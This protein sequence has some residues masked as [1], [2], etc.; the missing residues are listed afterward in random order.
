MYDIIASSFFQ[1]KTCRLPGIG[2]LSLINSS[3]ALDI[4]NGQIIAP[5][6]SI[7]FSPSIV[8]DGIFNEFSAISEVMLKRL[9]EV[10]SL[11][12]AGIGSF[13][14]NKEGIID[15]VAIKINPVFELPV[16]VESVIRQ[17][18]EHEILVGDK[19]TTNTV[20]SKMLHEQ[21]EVQ[22]AKKDFWWVWAILLGLIGIAMIAYYI[23]AFGIDNFGKV[24]HL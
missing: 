20:M 13:F 5:R 23:Y 17:N 11:E 16:I 22:S 8:S 1:T 18:K 24:N 21:E 14:I 3:A 9:A 2:Q 10:S 12:V 6:Q 7:V 19:T 15:F 4:A